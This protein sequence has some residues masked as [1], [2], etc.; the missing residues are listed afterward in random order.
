[1]KKI[2]LQIC[3]CFFA[4]NT[5][6]QSIA[7]SGSSSF[8]TALLLQQKQTMEQI[9]SISANGYN[10]TSASQSFQVTAPQV[11]VESLVDPNNYIQFVSEMGNDVAFY[12]VNN[13]ALLNK[14]EFSS[15]ENVSAYLSKINGIE[16]FATNG[17]GHFKLELKQQ[18]AAAILKN[19]FGFDDTTIQS[20]IQH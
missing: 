8:V 19:I 18:N 7:N 10:S 17:A 16:K 20:S 2:F 6:A 4:I 14:A 12:I 15:N 13:P 3:C 5:Q 9:K 1:M 11:S